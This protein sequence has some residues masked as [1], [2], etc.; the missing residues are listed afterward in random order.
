M[1]TRP[2]QHVG[3]M[4]HYAADR[5]RSSISISTNIGQ[6]IELSPQNVGTGSRHPTRASTL[7]K[8]H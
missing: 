1:P 6:T 8:Y 5:T 2:S 3:D 4:E 7:A